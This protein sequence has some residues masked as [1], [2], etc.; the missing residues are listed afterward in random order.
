M[1][2]FVD[3]SINPHVTASSQQTNMNP[4]LQMLSSSDRGTSHRQQHSTRTETVEEGKVKW[5]V[6]WVYVWASGLSMSALTLA[7]HLLFIAA[8]VG[9]NIW[10]SEWTSRD[11]VT[12]ERDVR[13]ERTNLSIYAALG[14]V[15]VF[16]ILIESLAVAHGC[17]CASRVLHDAMLRRCLRAPMSFFDTTPTGR[18]LNRFSKDL[19]LIDSKMPI[20]LRQ[21]LFALAPLL[22]TFVVISYSTP[23]FLSVVIP[24]TV[25]YIVVQRL[26]IS[27][28]RQLKRIDSVRKSPLYS[29]FDESVAGIVSIRAYR[30]VTFFVNQCDRLI[31]ESQRA[32]YLIP[33]VLRWLGV[34]M[35]LLG[36]VIVFLSCLFSILQRQSL[37]AGLAGLSI[38]YALQVT[39]YTNV[40]I[41]LA[42]EL[43]TY[44][45]SV[46]RVQ[47]YAEIMTEAATHV[48]EKRPDD[49]WPQ[50]GRIEFHEYSTRYRK[51][52][53]LVLRNISLNV[54]SG[55]KIGIVGRTCAGKSS[56][57]LALFRLLEAESGYIS[58][59]GVRI[60]DIGLHDLRSRLTI[61]PQDPTV[62]SGTIKE[63]LDPFGQHTD[64]ELWTVLDQV[65]LKASI[66]AL[67]AGLEHNLGN[68]GE[69]L[70]VGQRQLVCLA[71]AL[72]RRSRLLV[73][74]EA[75]AA[76]DHETDSFLQATIR[77]EFADCTVLTVAHRISTVIDY[78]RVLVLVD[79]EVREFDRPGVLMADDTSLFR[80][81]VQKAGISCGNA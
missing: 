12:G 49:D 42:C 39:A 31:N 37:T 69:L 74:D 4:S 26:Y 30:Q 40:T 57:S 32:W 9:T 29:H 23:A 16:S 27:A 53:G 1:I 28:V 55:E 54:N 21:W 64:V 18:I 35:E 48:P 2:H 71:R 81:M 66:S 67:S 63:N 61:I 50:K 47:E 17:V 38:S 44:M 34:N 79:G 3:P 5:R 10:L 41:R 8:Q 59:D 7:C 46:E 58:I 76:V 65:R 45:V 62:F 33:V 43:E 77:Q 36:S 52:L 70:S 68:G 75:T 73:L 15:Q 51:G 60:A 22:A 80:A 78:D 24:V 56:L 20:Q 6:I 19:Q 25:I 13:D 14:T 72:L 11:N